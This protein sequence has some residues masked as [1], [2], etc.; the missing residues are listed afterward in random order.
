MTKVSIEVHGG[1]GDFRESI[2]QTTRRRRTGRRTATYLMSDPRPPSPGRSMVS[3][4]QTTYLDEFHDIGWR[5]AEVL[6]RND[7]GSWTK[8]APNLYPHQWSWD[9]AFI[10]IRLSHLDIPR[11]AKDPDTPSDAQWAT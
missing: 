2:P 9:S 1:V 10:A 8:P 5:A 4:I 6:R 3:P 11:A 7:F